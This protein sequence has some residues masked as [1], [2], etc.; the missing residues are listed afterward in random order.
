MSPQHSRAS[1]DPGGT[2]HAHAPPGPSRPNPPWQRPGTTSD[3]DALYN[4]RRTNNERRG[5]PV[6]AVPGAVNPAGAVAGDNGPK[7]PVGKHL[8]NREPDHGPNETSSNLEDTPWRTLWT[9]ISTLVQRSFG[10]TT[11]P[12]P[13]DRAERARL[14]GQALLEC[15][16]RAIV[17]ATLGLA[18]LVVAVVAATMA[19]GGTFDI[20]DSPGLL[21][22]GD[23]IGR[24]ESWGTARVATIL[25]APCVVA[26]VVV[27]IKHVQRRRA[28]RLGRQ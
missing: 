10:Y 17:L 6:S 28:G 1:A 5:R 11:D 22:D 18:L 7:N 25:S 19:S 23:V 13:S 26:A 14:R 3:A 21:G 24:L 8:G 4:L 9:A 2:P 12:A 27:A 20:P 16:T 15:L